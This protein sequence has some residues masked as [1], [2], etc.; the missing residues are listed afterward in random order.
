MA[1]FE[2]DI[3]NIDKDLNKVEK[4]TKMGERLKLDK[5]VTASDINKVSKENFAKLV[6]DEK[7]EKENHFETS[8]KDVEKYLTAVE[9]EFMKTQRDKEA[10]NRKE[11]VKSMIGGDLWILSKDIKAPKEEEK[12]DDD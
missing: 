1:Q 10:E 4:E 7:K 2:D 3:E 11:Y 5:K 8:T 6:K 12:E 9:K